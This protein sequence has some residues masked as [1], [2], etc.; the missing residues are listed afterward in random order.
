MQAEA[1]GYLVSHKLG[2]NQ[3][4]Q[5]H[6][7]AL[8]DLQRSPEGLKN[9]ELQLATIQK[10]ATKL[11]EQIDQKLG[12]YQEKSQ[13]LAEGKT[14]QLQDTFHQKIEQAKSD[15]AEKLSNQVEKG[16]EL[17]SSKK[18]NRTLK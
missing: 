17:E 10:E 15:C 14:F 9:F 16:K 2:L 18:E 13:S 6:F 5:Y 3:E 7:S 1:V 8:N 11:M 12:H 4:N